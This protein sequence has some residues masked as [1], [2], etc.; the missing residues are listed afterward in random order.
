MA[1]TGK[2]SHKR[3][4]NEAPAGDIAVRQGPQNGMRVFDVYH[5][6]SRLQSLVCAWEKKDH[7]PQLALL[8]LV[9]AVGSRYLLGPDEAR[10]LERL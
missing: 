2:I 3:S 6:S 9:D 7:E 8:P 10:M 5:R 4:S 1:A